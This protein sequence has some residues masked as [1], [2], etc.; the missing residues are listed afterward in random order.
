MRSHDVS[1]RQRPAQLGR[2]SRDR[3]LRAVDELRALERERQRRR[4]A[5]RPLE[6]VTRRFEAKAREVFRISHELDAGMEGRH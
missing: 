6:E 4:A 5:S 1:G 3:L 2:E